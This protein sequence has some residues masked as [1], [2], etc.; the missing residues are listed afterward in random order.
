MTDNID[1]WELLREAKYAMEGG[2]EYQ[3]DM[4]D[5][6]DEAL[7]IYDGVENNGW[8]QDHYAFCSDIGDVE[9]Y[10]YPCDGGWKYQLTPL[11]TFSELSE[12]QTAA[13]K[14]ARNI[15]YDH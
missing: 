13:D 7:K 8:V 9:A 15:L 2:T 11:K 14:A 3:K 5:I 4:S 12:A 6:I 1:P 10:V